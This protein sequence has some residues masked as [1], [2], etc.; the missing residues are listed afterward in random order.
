MSWVRQQKQMCKNINRPLKVGDTIYIVKW[1]YNNIIKI[2]L[3]NIFYIDMH[4]R[5]IVRGNA[6]IINCFGKTS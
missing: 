2:K 3:S 1:Y 5:T 6:E 4:A